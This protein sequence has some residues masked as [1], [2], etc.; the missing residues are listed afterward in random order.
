MAA[1]ERPLG[2]STSEPWAAGQGCDWQLATG[3][4]AADAALCSTLRL[5]RVLPAFPPSPAAPLQDSVGNI[6]IRRPGS[7][8]GEAAPPVIVQGGQGRTSGRCQAQLCTAC[9]LLVYMF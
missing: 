5:R 8:G 3:A 7:G 1:G 9:D 6:V 4:G 2:P